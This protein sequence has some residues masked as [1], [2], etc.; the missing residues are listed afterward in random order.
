MKKVLILVF[1][2]VGV[3]FANNAQF[4]LGEYGPKSPQIELAEL[5]AM[6]ASAKEAGKTVDP[7]WQEQVR[8]CDVRN[9]MAGELWLKAGQK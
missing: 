1:V 5:E 4:R 8:Q 2:M 7:A 6:I 3:V 9:Q